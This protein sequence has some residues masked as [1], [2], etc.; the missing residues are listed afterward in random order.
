LLLAIRTSVCVLRA[1]ADRT[2][3]SVSVPQLDMHG[4][5]VIS[6]GHVGTPFPVLKCLRTHYGRDCEPLP[7]NMHWIA[8]CF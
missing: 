1:T 7:A 6:R 8:F 3:L 2:V 5:G 4:L